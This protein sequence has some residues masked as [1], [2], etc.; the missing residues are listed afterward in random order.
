MKKI[1]VYLDMDGTIADLYGQ[2]NWLEMLEA[3][4]DGAF[5]MCEPLTDEET[6]YKLFPTDK[7]EIKVL[8]MTPKNATANYCERVIAEK[9]AWLDR[10]FPKIQK[11]FY[12]PYGNNKNLRNS[13]NAILIDDNATIRDNFRGIALNP[14][15]LW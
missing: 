2:E 11:R 6:L 7:Y 8:S 5:I 3:E 10:H 14:A 13:K 9:N 1:N 15:D 4:A 12:L